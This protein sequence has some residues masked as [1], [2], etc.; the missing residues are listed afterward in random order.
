[1]QIKSKLTG[2]LGS[3][4]QLLTMY[5]QLQKDTDDKLSDIHHDEKTQFFILNEA[6]NQARKL[7]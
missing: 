4:D 5:Q 1:M 2:C 7:L 3:I 6:F